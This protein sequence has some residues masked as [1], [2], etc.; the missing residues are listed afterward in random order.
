MKF[1]IKSNQIE[2]CFPLMSYER[3][4]LISKSGDISRLFK[5]EMPQIYTSSTKE[6]ESFHDA[7]SRAVG[8]LPT[9]SI[10]HKQDIFCESEYEDTDSGDSFLEKA[11]KRHFDGRVYIRHIC[12]VYVT[13][14]T[15]KGFSNTSMS[16]AILRNKIVPQ[17]QLSPERMGKFMDAVG[18]FVHIISENG[19]NIEELSKDE[20][21]G[22]PDHF[23]MIEQYMSLN[24]TGKNEVL[25]DLH[26]NVDKELM[27]GDN[28]VSC[29]SIGDLTN[30]PSVISPDIRNEKL[31]TDVSELSNCYVSQLCMQLPFNHIY[32]QYIFIGDSTDI[33]KG[34]EVQ[35]KHM[36]SFSAISRENAINKEFNDD[37][38][39]QAT[40]TGEKCVYAGYNIL[41]WDTS[42]TELVKKN[43]QVAGAMSSLA[44]TAEK[45][46]GIVPQLFWAGIPGASSN[47][48]REMRFLTF[49]PQSC[50]FLN[51]ESN[52][53]DIT[54]KDRLGLK[55][56]DRPNGVPVRVDVSNYPMDLGWTTN[57]N[58]FILGPSGSGKSFFT[59]VMMSQKYQQG[60]HLVIVDVGDSYL[61]LCDL[62][63]EQTHGQDGIYYTYTEEH[64][65]S[66]NPFYVE[67]YV[68]SEEKL[69]QLRSL[70][71]VLWK[72]EDEKIT[73]SEE[74]QLT[75]AINL[76]IKL[77]TKH[78]YGEEGG[79]RPCFDTFYYFLSN[80]YKKYVQDQGVQRDN[81]DIDNLLQVLAPYA[82]GGKYDF[83]L[84]SREMLD[85]LHKRFIV[86]ELDNIKDNKV[87]FP[88]VTL[89]LMDTF[90]AKMRRLAPHERKMIVIEEAWKAISKGGTA[91]F[92]KYL[93]KT[94]R[95]HNGE[96]AVVT[97]EVDDIIGNEIVKNAIINNADEK[98]LLDQ[99]KFLNRFD[100]IQGVLALSD[101]EKALVLSINK[102]L[103]FQNR[104]PYKEVFISFNGTFSA[105]YGVEVSREEQLTYS[106]KKEEKG[107]LLLI[108]KKVGS[109]E[110]AIKEYIKI[111][112]K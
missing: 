1:S 4:C 70:L 12:Y 107:E 85:L 76:Y 87:L 78:K 58:K 33:L 46:Q 82:K 48:P 54:G 55:L 49:I 67:D 84:N 95:K 24:Y 7:W 72:N 68:Y 36:E 2:N 109:M 74:T 98:I 77:I 50:C 18:Q 26:L 29:Y 110:R 66:F 111:H 83:L 61:G 89:V 88:V 71:C 86:F 20:I 34:L 14:S 90:I 53:K 47:Y 5:V 39:N 23:G 38:L 32:N 75:T 96:V 100:E 13:M 3:N 62:I 64:P 17:E 25:Q 101:K 91:E 99:S 8:A 40:T 21:I 81:F 45:V 43:T 42:Y 9:Y 56:T 16:N 102:D 11:S 10:V 22:T 112:D 35:G 60:D 97:Q 63:R 94:V 6:I 73:K 92:I 15:K 69:E 51:F 57:K 93:Y 52:Y 80:Y 59:N 27:I 30:I 106:T 41:T 103:D 44:C 104:P 65:I 31:S 19:F 28:Y 79:I 105:V 37:F 108:E